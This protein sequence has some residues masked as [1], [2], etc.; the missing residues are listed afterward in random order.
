MS[1]DLFI[2]QHGDISSAELKVNIQVVI[3]INA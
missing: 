1:S 3:S 2:V